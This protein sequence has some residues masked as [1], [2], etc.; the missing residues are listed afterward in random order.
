MNMKRI[1]YV[2]ALLCAFDFAAFG[3]GTP[4]L[5]VKEVDGSPN[6]LGVTTIVVS[7]GTLTIS[8]NTATITTA[9]GSSDIAIGTT[10]ITG[11]TTT[12]VLYDNAGVVGEYTVTGTGN[13]VMSASPTL[14]G[15]IVAV[16]AQVDKDDDYPIKRYDRILFN[17]K[18]AI[19]VDLEG[20]NR[21]FVIPVEDVVAVFRREE[22]S[23]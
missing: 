14:T 19:P 6:K 4:P 21:L 20:D 13:V 17:P 22:E 15:R 18:H 3:Q 12:R 8:G 1:L 23:A 5:R 7:N 16:S 9:S 10:A 2:A 11:G